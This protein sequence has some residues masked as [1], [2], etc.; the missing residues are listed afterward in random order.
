MASNRPPTTRVSDRPKRASPALGVS[1]IRPSS[2]RAQVLLCR[3]RQQ[4]S[5][6]KRST[7]AHASRNVVGSG[8]VGPE[9]ITLRSSP[10]T[11]EIAR[12]TVGPA[13]AAASRPPLTADRCFRMV[14]SAVISAPPFSSAFTAVALV[15]E[16]Q[17]AGRNGHQRGR[18]AREQHNQR[19]PGIRTV[20]DL[21]RASSGRDAPLIWQRMA[22]RN[23]FE[24]RGQRDRQMC[25]DDDAASQSDR[26][27]RPRTAC[28]MNGAALPTAITRRPPSRRDRNRGILDGRVR[29]DDAETR[30]RSRRGQC[31]ENAGGSVAGASSQ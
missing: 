24:P 8:T 1:S 9:P 4:S 18:A 23:P 12:H 27:P 15:V 25:A 30:P 26:R 6:P 17:V 10:T 3:R 20:R 19:L 16:R 28:A 31:S 13:A 21:E 2:P 7:Y 22:R 14:F 11:S 5:T 29:S